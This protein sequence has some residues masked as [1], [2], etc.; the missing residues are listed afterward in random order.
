MEIYLIDLLIYQTFLI[1]VIFFSIVCFAAAVST[2]LTKSLSRKFLRIK[3]SNFPKVTVQ[4]P[5][6]N[7][8]VALRCIEKCMNFDYPKDKFEIVVADDSDENKNQ[9]M[10]DEFIENCPDNVK[11][12]RRKTRKGFKAGALNNALKYSSGDYIVIFDSDFTPKRNFL[13]KI[14][15]PFLSDEK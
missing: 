9:D 8:A 7:E 10:I 15:I 11:L 6:Y 13:K 1:P 4:I 14:I 3:N 2:V 12:V 5:V